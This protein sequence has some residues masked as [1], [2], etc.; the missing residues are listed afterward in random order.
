M[1]GPALPLWKG[2]PPS[3]PAVGEDEAR[4]AVGVPD[5][6]ALAFAAAAQEG[7]GTAK[8]AEVPARGRTRAARGGREV[9]MVGS[10]EEKKSFV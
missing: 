3:A 6:F 1:R 10:K 9:L 4:R 7:G 8:A 2:L 5:A